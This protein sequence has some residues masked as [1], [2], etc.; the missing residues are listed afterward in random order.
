MLSS[1]FE[2]A[3]TCPHGNG[4]STVT[5][6]VNMLKYVMFVICV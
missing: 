6:S 3:V 4:D 5:V 1:S 2:R